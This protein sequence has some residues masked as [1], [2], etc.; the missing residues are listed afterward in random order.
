MLQVIILEDDQYQRAYFQELVTNRIM[1]NP[2]PAAYDMKLVLVTSEA[3]A[4]IDYVKQHPNDP[5]LLLADVEL[6]QQPLNGIDVAEQVRSSSD[7]SL[8]IFISSYPSYLPLTIT[9]RIEP[10]DY[11]DKHFDQDNL[12]ERIRQSLD[13]AYQRYLKR[14]M[15]KAVRLFHYSPAKGIHRQIPF[16]QIYY[17]QAVP[18]HKRLLEIVGEDTRVSF[19]GELSQIDSNAFFRAS[20]SLFINLDRINSFDSSKRLISFDDNDLITCQ[21]SARRVAALKKSLQSRGK[22]DDTM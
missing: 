11:I 4:V 9:R 17:I 20:R 6:D 13:I 19:H 8:I 3:Q 7:F 21:C 10:L 16:H 5:L 15:A 1:I 22:E 12:A 18:N 2:T 14:T